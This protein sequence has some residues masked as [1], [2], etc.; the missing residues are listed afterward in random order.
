MY[1]IYTFRGI[2]VMLDRDLAELLNPT[3]QKN[4]TVQIEV[5]ING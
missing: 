1:K 2:A 3:V 4:S 5:Y